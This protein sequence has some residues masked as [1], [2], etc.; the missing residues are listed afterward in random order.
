VDNPAAPSLL[1]SLR[2]AVHDNLIRENR[3][4]LILNG[5]GVTLLISTLSLLLGTVLGF[6]VCALNMSR[7]PLLRRLGSLYLAFFR[8][9]PVLVLL[10]LLFY[11]AFARV[12]IHAVPVAIIAFSLNAAAFIG[13][14]IR[15]AILQVDRGQIEAA[16]SL[17]YSRAGAFRLVTLPQAARSALPVYKSEFISL[18]KS[19]AIVGYI[20]IQDLTRAGDIIRSRTFDA[21]F[22]LLVVAAI[23]LLITALGARLFDFI[24]LLANHKTRSAP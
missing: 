13:E 16:R 11:V 22:P 5:L 8:G 7:N 23:Y 21:F 6:G 24:G 12:N 9:T 2:S 18:I 10:L 4:R 17:G 15:A 3:W 14:I 19:T 1:Q 20:A